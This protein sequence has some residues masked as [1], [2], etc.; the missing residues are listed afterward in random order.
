[1]SLEERIEANKK[2]FLE[3]FVLSRGNISI[4]C[5]N[6]G[7][8][9]TTYYE[10]VKNDKVFEQSVN[11]ALETNKDIAETIIQKAIEGFTY[12]EEVTEYDDKGKVL[13][14]KKIKKHQSPDG[15]LALQFLQAKA[16]ERGYGKT[17]DITSGG[18]PIQT[19]PFVLV[20]KED[21][22]GSDTSE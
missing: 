11:D 2:K 18:K 16:Q 7:I 15:K 6:S 4:A 21:E 1:M 9:R 14:T 22:D 10:W 20:V 5:A 19:A 17:L 3:Q 8:T 13:R 12:V